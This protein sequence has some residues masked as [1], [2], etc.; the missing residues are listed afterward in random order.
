MGADHYHHNEFSRSQWLAQLR[1][2]AAVLRHLP[3][4]EALE[5]LEVVARRSGGWTWQLRYV[6]L[7]LLKPDAPEEEEAEA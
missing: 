2:L 6:G 5:L 4:D 1:E 3:E 7:L